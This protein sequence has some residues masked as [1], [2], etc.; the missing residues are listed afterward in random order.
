MLELIFNVFEISIY[1]FQCT[2]FSQSPS[3]IDIKNWECSMLYYSTIALVCNIILYHT[4]Y[5]FKIGIKSRYNGL[6]KICEMAR[7]ETC[8]Q[9]ALC[10][11]LNACNTLS[12]FTATRATFYRPYRYKPDLII[13]MNLKSAIH[14]HYERLTAWDLIYYVKEIVI[15]CA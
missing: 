2:H 14:S 10:R 13:S 6:S 8:C 3:A 9:A 12:A 11:F 15:S 5:C 1:E 4:I 7:F